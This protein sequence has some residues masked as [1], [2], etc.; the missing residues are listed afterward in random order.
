MAKPHKRTG[1]RSYGKIARK[2]WRS[3]RFRKLA[4]F[5]Q[6]LLLYL[7]TCPAGETS[8]SIFHIGLSQI[9]DDLNADFEKVKSSI[10]N[11]SNGD[12]FRYDFEAR[13]IF[14]PK[15]IEYDPPDNHFALIARIRRTRELPD[16]DLLSQFMRQLAPFVERFKTKI[17][18]ETMIYFRHCL[19]QPEKDSI[20]HRNTH[21]LE[22]GVTIGIVL[23]EPNP[24]PESE[25]NPIPQSNPIDDAFAPLPP[26]N[27]ITVS[28][29]TRPS[30]HQE[31]IAFWC[32]EY[33]RTLKHKY[34][35]AG[36]SEGAMIKSLLRQFGPAILRGMMITLINT[37]DDFVRDK[38]GITI[39]TLKNDAML[40][41]QK[42]EG[43]GHGTKK[44][45]S[46]AA[47]AAP[48]KYSNIGLG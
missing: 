27:A 42:V 47:V 10:V 43:T 32:T 20:S 1:E 17:D 22:D 21:R 38:R 14:L 15:Q 12:W 48:D 46:N 7:W 19:D 45:Q 5:D 37:D 29:S 33:E 6:R 26:P 24:K 3:V 40:L 44:R 41:A 28:H 39:K 36:P 35:F 2:T 9:A 34:R 13:V 8:G 31:A 30:D 4:D 18:D 25:P 16:T 23:P 11:L